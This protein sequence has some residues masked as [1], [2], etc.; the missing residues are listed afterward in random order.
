MEYLVFLMHIDEKNRKKER[1]FKKK[2][3]ENSS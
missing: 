1:K 3:G 2:N